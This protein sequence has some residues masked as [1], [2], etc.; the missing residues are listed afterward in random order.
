MINATSLAKMRAG[1]LIV[2]CSRG[3]LIDEPALASALQSGR[4]SAALDVF[5]EEPLPAASS[6]RSSPNLLL[7]PHAAWYSE[8]A[9]DRLQQLACDEI[10]RGMTGQ[11]PR[12]PVPVSA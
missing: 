2:N 5:R 11:T 1:A 10:D 6:L 12:C 8:R 7:T 4:L 3:D 9:I